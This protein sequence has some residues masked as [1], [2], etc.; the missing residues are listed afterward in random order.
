VIPV[1]GTMPLTV[2][3]LGAIAAI[4][5][6]EPFGMMS[7]PTATAAVPIPGWQVIRRAADPV[8]LLTKNE[9]LPT[10]LDGDEAGLVLVIVDRA[11]RSWNADNYFVVAGEAQALS[12]KWLPEASD[13]ELLGKVILVLR[14][15][16]VLEEGHTQDLY[17][18]DE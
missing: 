6:Q 11:A 12:L 15:K 2:T 10:P 18:W 5:P 1:V 16:K 13:V 7:F 9:D 14:P 17:T 4:V 3:D 8:V